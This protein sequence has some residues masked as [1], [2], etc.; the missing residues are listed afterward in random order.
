[1]TRNFT[2]D[3]YR[4]KYTPNALHQLIRLA[5]DESDNPEVMREVPKLRMAVGQTT[6]STA[7]IRENYA[8]NYAYARGAFPYPSDFERGRAEFDA[9]LA[10]YDSMR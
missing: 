5:A 1:M 4:E 2:V 9:W 8:R 7:E 3:E 6:L 10:E